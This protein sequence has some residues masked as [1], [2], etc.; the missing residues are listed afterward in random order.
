MLILNSGL[1][2]LEGERERERVKIRPE[3]LEIFALNSQVSEFRTVAENLCHKT[4]F[5]K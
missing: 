5:L 4:T 2:Y 1:L 3:R